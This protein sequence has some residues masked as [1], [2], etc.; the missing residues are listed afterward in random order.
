MP[1]GDLILDDQ[2]LIVLSIVVNYRYEYWYLLRWVA[3][4]VAR[5][6]TLNLTVAFVQNQV[7]IRLVTAIIVSLFKH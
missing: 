7:L 1:P 3:P 6:V 4:G 2:C 5:Q